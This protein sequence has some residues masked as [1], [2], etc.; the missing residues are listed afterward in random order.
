MIKLTEI[1]RRLSEDDTGDQL[2]DYPDRLKSATVDGYDVWLLTQPA[3]DSAL[4]GV[5]VDGHTRIFEVETPYS[6][7]PVNWDEFKGYLKKYNLP[8]SV[9]KYIFGDINAVND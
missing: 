8:K 5:L 3:K 4:Y 6:H 1:A 7:G 9:I 2:D